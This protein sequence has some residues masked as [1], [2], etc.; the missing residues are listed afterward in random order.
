MDN[1]GKITTEKVLSEIQQQCAEDAYVAERILKWSE[2]YFSP[3][4][5]PES[6]RLEFRRT[7]T[8]FHPINITSDGKLYLQMV[9]IKDNMAC[10]RED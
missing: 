3:R 5:N 6:I 9:N 4:S 2:R 10:F 8:G 7:P 1:A